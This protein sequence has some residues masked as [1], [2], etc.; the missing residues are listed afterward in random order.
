MKS[1]LDQLPPSE[2]NRSEWPYTI[3]SKSLPDRNPDGSTWPRITI[4]TPSY[5]QGE[6][7]E[8]TI[9]SVLLQ[10]YPNLEYIIIDGGS[11]DHT[12]DI[13]KKY[14]PWIDYW[15]SEPDHGQSDAI[16]KG[17]SKS[18]GIYGNWIN[19]DDLLAKDALY[20]AA[21]YLPNSDK[22]T[23]FIGKCYITN[24][25][26]S[27]TKLVQSTIKSFEQL[28]NIKH[29]WRNNNSISQQNVL[30]NLE[31]FKNVGGLN[32]G[33][34]FAM[35]FELWGDLLLSGCKIE[36]LDFPMGIFR[37]YEGQKISDKVATTYCL[38]QTAMRLI[39]KNKDW[40]LYKKLSV[41]FSLFTYKTNYRYKYIRKKFNMRKRFY[42]HF[43]NTLTG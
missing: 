42:S 24:R 22:K 41:K 4:V 6:F 15:I 30:F 39:N 28:I 32:V 23:L 25:D 14:E 18:T 20:K 37:Q 38:I 29:E 40:S 7:I 9:R 34:N 26:R 36:K 10:N 33:N 1:L 35:D 27:Q 11:T 21:S 17:F 2:E 5:N 13:I 8:E 16:N 19:S 43:E 12:L 31:N 3:E